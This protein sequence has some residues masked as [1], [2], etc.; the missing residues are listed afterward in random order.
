MQRGNEVG[1]QVRKQTEIRALDVLCIIPWHFMALSQYDYARPMRVLCGLDEKADEKAPA[2][3][4]N[5]H[6]KWTSRVTNRRRHKR[7]TS[8][9]PFNGNSWLRHNITMRG[10]CAPDEKADEE[11]PA[12]ACSGETKLVS[13]V[14]NKQRSRR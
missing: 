1:K 3:A 12:R 7:W 14:T 10:L 13:K 2:H 11:A 9:V 5:G 8:H 6:T 4:C